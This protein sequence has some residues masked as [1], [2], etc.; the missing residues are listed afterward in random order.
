[1]KEG[2]GG[3]KFEI[4]NKSFHNVFQIAISRGKGKG[5]AVPVTPWRPIGL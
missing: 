5:N 1:M 3:R 2:K 4:L